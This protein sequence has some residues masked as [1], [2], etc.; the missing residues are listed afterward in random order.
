MCAA[1]SDPGLTQGHYRACVSVQFGRVRNLL[2]KKDDRALLYSK[3]QIMTRTSF[4]AWLSEWQSSEDSRAQLPLNDHWLKALVLKRKNGWEALLLNSHRD[5]IQGLRMMAYLAAT[6][7]S[8]KFRLVEFSV[9]FT[10]WK[11]KC[12]P[13]Y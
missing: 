6:V 13:V 5:I 7:L 8:R 4:L 3:A 9:Q 1:V 10:S 12:Q 2:K 11:Q